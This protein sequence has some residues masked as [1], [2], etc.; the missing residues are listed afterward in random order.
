MLATALDSTGCILG[1]GIAPPRSPYTPTPE[2]RL[3]RDGGGNSAT[4]AM[5]VRPVGHRRACRGAAHL[6]RGG[7]DR[8]TEL[9][10]RRRGAD[11]ASARRRL[12]RRPRPLRLPALRPRLL[13]R[14]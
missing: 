11:A 9:S 6:G 13:L 14:P 12:Q 2:S 7:P 1:T 5:D 10:L 3:C 8:R 4:L